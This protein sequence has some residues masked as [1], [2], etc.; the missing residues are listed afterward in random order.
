[1]V[2]G[3][4]RANLAGESLPAKALPVKTVLILDTFAFG[5]QFDSLEPLEATVR[6]HVPGGV[7]FQ[8]E[9][10]EG[11]RYDEGYASSLVRTLRQLQE[12]QKL[13]LVV[14]HHYAPLR[15]VLT[16][17]REI[18]EGVPVVF[19][20]VQSARFQSLTLGSDVTGVTSQYHIHST[21]DLALRLKPD[22]KT[23][24]VIGED[25]ASGQLWLDEADERAP[26]SCGHS[27]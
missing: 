9:R 22:T 25:S 18:F 26:S 21:L 3:G 7:N 24:A 13:D 16:H 20:D 8:V 10:E 27:Q 2:A 1:L 15:F 4:S 12:G 23:V 11:Y 14:V 5:E 19:M 17:R 6:S